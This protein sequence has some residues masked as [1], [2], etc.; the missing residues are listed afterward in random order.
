MKQSFFKFFGL[1]MLITYSCSSVAQQQSEELNELGNTVIASLQN[2][3]LD[4]FL[5]VHATE[6]DYKELSNKNSR[7]ATRKEPDSPQEEQDFKSVEANFKQNFEDI[8]QEGITRQINWN[9]VQFSRIENNASHANEGKMPV[10]NNPLI[11]FTYKGEEMKL[12][13][14]KVAKLNRGWVILGNITLQ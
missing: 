10:I 3:D 5:K 14:D 12:K 6:K 13:A 9:E 4:S 7:I 11:A 1:L 8:I 2:N